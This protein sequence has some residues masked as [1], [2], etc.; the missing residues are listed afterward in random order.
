MTNNRFWYIWCR[1]SPNSVEM[2]LCAQTPTG[3]SHQTPQRY[4]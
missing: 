1:K 2:M 3:F 4:S